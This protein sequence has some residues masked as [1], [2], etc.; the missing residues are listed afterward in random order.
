MGVN[1]QRVLIKYDYQADGC[2]LIFPAGWLGA[3]PHI[4]Q[5]RFNREATA[6]RGQQ[7]KDDELSDVRWGYEARHSDVSSRGLA[8]GLRR[9]D[10]PRRIGFHAAAAHRLE[11]LRAR[12]VAGGGERA[13]ADGVGE[14]CARISVYLHGRRWR[15]RRADVFA[16]S[17]ELSDGADERRACVHEQA[18]LKWD[19]WV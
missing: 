19:P 13:E 7:R 16:V 1:F 12:A 3:V 5:E 17:G 11:L 4:Q 18:L 14:I 9:L 8:H 10:V 2:D 15:S 6:K